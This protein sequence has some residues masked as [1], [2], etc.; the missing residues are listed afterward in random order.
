MRK[1]T[2]YIDRYKTDAITIE[3]F[4]LG[5]MIKVDMNGVAVGE[6]VVK[7]ALDH[8]VSLELPNGKTLV[9]SK[10]KVMY[11]LPQLEYTIDGKVLYDS[12]THPE[13]KVKEIGKFFY[14]LAALSLLPIVL[15][16]FKSGMI[17]NYI[18][19]GTIIV[20]FI[21]FVVGYLTKEK[22]S[23][24]AL[25]FGILFLVFD[26]ALVVYSSIKSGESH[27]AFIIFRI[28]VLAMLADGFKAMRTIEPASETDAELLDSNI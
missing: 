25:L 8:S 27:I 9:V 16:Y 4:S 23:K 3:I 1:S 22:T 18:A 5:K 14:Y 6:F 19:L 7:E 10:K 12:P 26:L 24:I 15:S 2:F 17:N 11:F 20:S 13:K 28:W 21:Y